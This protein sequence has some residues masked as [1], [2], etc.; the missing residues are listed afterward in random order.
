MNSEIKFDKIET[1]KVTVY[2]NPSSHCP[3]FTIESNTDATNVSEIK[4]ENDNKCSNVSE[5]IEDTLSMY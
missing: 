1:I 2:K 5:I 3:I 4:I